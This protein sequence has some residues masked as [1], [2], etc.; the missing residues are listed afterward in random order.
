MLYETVLVE[1]ATSRADKEALAA[2][3]SR[4]N[5]CPFCAE[6][7]ALLSRVAAE[8]RDRAALVSGV[9]DGIADPHRRGLVAWAAATREPHSQLLRSPPFEEHDAPEVIGT[10]FA[11]HYIN[12][13]VE[14]F[15]GHKPVQA[16]PAPLRGVTMTLLGRVAARAMRRSRQRG[17]TLRMLPESPLPDDLAWAMPSPA[18]AGALARFAAAVER[19][20]SEAL[21]QPERARVSAVLAEWNGAD[22]PL[23]GDW[24]ERALHGLEGDSRSRTRVAV[25]AALAPVR[26]D[27]TDVQAFKRA[28]PL[29]RH[30]LGAVAWSALGAARRIASWLTPPPLVAQRTAVSV[31]PERAAM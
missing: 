29:D 18:I 14:V 8:S 23:Y 12:R 10:A 5:D 7:H 2:T 31:P 11:F 21:R 19:A 25:L 30:L 22:P 24:L 4:I 20:G 26:I 13:L 6:A 3:V 28:Q 1:G 27:E 17:R 16:G 15:Q 9:A